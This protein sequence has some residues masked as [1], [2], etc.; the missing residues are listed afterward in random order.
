MPLIPIIPDVPPQITTA[1]TILVVSVDVGQTE[2]D[3]SLIEVP[4]DFGTAE[5]HPS[6]EPQAEPEGTGPFGF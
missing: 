3:D 4:I 1:S 6:R 5:A 2:Q